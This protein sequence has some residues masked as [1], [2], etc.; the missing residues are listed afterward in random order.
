MALEVLRL[1]P[2]VV[3]TTRVVHISLF[4]RTIDVRTNYFTLTR[5]QATEDD[6]IPFSAPIKTSS[7]EEVSSLVIK[8]GETIT[9]PILYMNRAE[10]FWGPNATEFEPERWVE[11]EGKGVAGAKEIQGHRHLLTFSDGA[12]FCLGRNFALVEF[13]VYF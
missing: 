1:H 3:A 9:A 2:P 8:K 7:G 6:V 13:K 11:P 10:M 5:L 4:V 12:R